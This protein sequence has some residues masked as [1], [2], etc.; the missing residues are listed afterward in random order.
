M[1]KKYIFSSSF[2]R[3][4]VGLV[5]TFVTGSVIA[6]NFRDYRGNDSVLVR[7]VQ[8]VSDAVNLKIQRDGDRLSTRDLMDALD[9]LQILARIVQI[10]DGRDGR[11]PYNRLTVSGA[12]ESGLSF[13]FQ[14]QTVH[15]I[16]SQCMSFAD[17]KFRGRVSVKN[18]SVSVNYG[19]TRLLHNRLSYWRTSLEICRQIT[20]VVR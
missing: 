13:Y 1:E 7:R 12:I 19:P 15:E 17:S 6:D 14:G 8:R 18:I 9:Q 3:W 2:A 16:H 4:F 5:L 20:G 10:D 11:P